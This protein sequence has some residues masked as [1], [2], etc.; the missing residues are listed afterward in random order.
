MTSAVAMLNRPSLK[1]F[2]CLIPLR[3][4]YIFL[5]LLA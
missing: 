5:F 3:Q 2:A 4:R 1:R